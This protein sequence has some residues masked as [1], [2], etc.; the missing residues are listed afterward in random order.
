[1]KTWQIRLAAWV[2]FVLGVAASWA[3]YNWLSLLSFTGTVLCVLYLLGSRPNNGPFMGSGDN[4]GR[5]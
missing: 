5:K 2:L 1:M 3:N 4:D